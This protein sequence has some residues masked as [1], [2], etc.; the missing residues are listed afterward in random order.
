MD[1]LAILDLVSK[2]LS[3]ISTLETVG[4]SVLPAVKVVADLV[5]GAQAGT[6]TSQQ[7]TDTEATLDSMIAA[8]NA[9]L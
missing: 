4:Q 6:V 8:F 5:T 1:I 9:P 2:G 7:L 3:V